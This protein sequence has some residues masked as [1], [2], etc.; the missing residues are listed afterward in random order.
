[1]RAGVLVQ[2]DNRSGSAAET[3]STRV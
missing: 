2:G 3:K 1:M